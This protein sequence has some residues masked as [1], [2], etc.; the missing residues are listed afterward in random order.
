MASTF[1]GLN[2]GKTGLYAYQA[3]IDTTAHN[4]SNAETDGYSRQ[5][6]GQKAGK[7]LR[8][9][10]TYGMAGTGVTV[11]GVTQMRDLYYD[12]KYWSNSSLYGEYAGKAYYMS[13]IENYFNEVKESGFTTTYNSL[14]DS[15]SE[16]QKNPSSSTVRTQVINYAKSLTE[17]FNS[18]SSNLKSV[19]E[20]CNF[21][22]R[23]QVDQINSISQQL[24]A[25]TKQ[26]NTLEIQ[27]GMANDLRDQRALLIDELSQI[28]NVSVDERKVGA[29]GS[30]VTSYVV[31]LDGVTLVD[32]I[33]TNKLIVSPREDKYSQNDIDGLYDIYWANGQKFD[34]RSPSLGGSLQAVLEVRDGN[35]QEN[36]SGTV[37][38][39][40][41]DDFL[42]VEDSNINEVETLNI[43][44]TGT[45]TVGNR[46]Y[47]YTGFEVTKDAD[48]GKFTYTFE[49]EEPIAADATDVKASIGESI[50]F[51]GI[52]YYQ[53]QLNQFVRTFA[54]LF[55][56]VHR[57]G[58][59]LEGAAGTDLFN[60]TNKISG[61]N[62]TFGPLA[63][64]DDASYYDYDTFNSQTGGYYEEIPDNQPLYGSYYF[65]TAENF[66]VSESFF[67]NP[68]LLAA[69]SD[70]VNGIE[71]N[72]IVDKL[73]ALKDNKTAFEQGTPEAF[74]Q[75][76]V[77]E[78]GID[79][80]K[81]GTIAESQ[82]DILK[83]ITNQRL[84]ISGVDVDEE[85][86]NLI[87]YQNAYNLSA[88]V[89]TVMNEIYH[90]L[91]N[92]MGV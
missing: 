73:I 58:V 30:G 59:D 92:E 90:K 43:P 9:N 40:A 81:A 53:S 5:V 62:Y 86:M 21:E 74:F 50:N 32:G 70:I 72:S 45:I 18:V 10:S 88:K 56:D 37:N 2:I 25:L 33:E 28:A 29:S 11:T 55:N 41:G 75:T 35:N 61:R 84:S 46:N 65:V 34:E 6:M 7:A 54:R 36:F 31:K 77:A 23:N 79:S 16:L 38:A 48:T 68:G 42:I 66:T 82:S 91:I 83:T 80:D 49:L 3:A 76:M 69:S 85:A 26:I 57:T 78:I 47:T 22:I 17:F 60:G 87:R 19:Q 27:G 44:E 52:P 1:F 51:K 89:I 8:M 64:S 63:G 20:E 15:L 12:E 14:F 39:S 13:E 67:K 71:D 4:I 24:A